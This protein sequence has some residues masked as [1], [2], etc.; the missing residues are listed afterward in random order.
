M[1]EPGTATAT[2]QAGCGTESAQATASLGRELERLGNGTTAKADERQLQR[3]VAALGVARRSL[4][5]L[6][7][8]EQA[9][10]DNGRGSQAA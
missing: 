5:V 10:A 6:V 9:E 7:R 1:A 4:A 3:I 8:I 2:E